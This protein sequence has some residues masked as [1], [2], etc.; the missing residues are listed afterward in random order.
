MSDNRVTFIVE[1][2][3]LILIVCSQYCFFVFAACF[4]KI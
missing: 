1:F 2:T 4:V 3:L